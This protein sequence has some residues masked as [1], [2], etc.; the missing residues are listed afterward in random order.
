MA[1]CASAAKSISS[2]GSR[3]V[4]SVIPSDGIRRAA[5]LLPLN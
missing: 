3:M 1:A 4:T 5:L 2:T